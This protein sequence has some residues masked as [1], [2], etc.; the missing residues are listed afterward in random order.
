[1]AIV[2]ASIEKTVYKTIVHSA[3]NQIIADEPIDKG[4]QDLGFSPSE[5]L[6]SALA[7]CTCITLRMY[8]DRK[9]WPLTDI[10]VKVVFQRDKESNISHFH[11]EITFNGQ[12][13]ESQRERL[14]QIANGCPIHRTLTH[15]IRIQTTL[16]K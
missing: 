8:A 9:G 6:A 2:T 13:D 4:G 3:T 14:L 11:C 15:P 7:T 12:L 5:L 1:M 16:T 10:Q